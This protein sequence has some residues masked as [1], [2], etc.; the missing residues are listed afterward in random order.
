MTSYPIEA[1]ETVAFTPPS[2]R[3]LPTP[4]TFTLRPGTRRDK[5][6][7]ERLLTEENLRSHDKHA[8]RDEMLKA[9]KELWSEET[10]YAE[11]GRLK[12]YWD[13]SDQF[14]ELGGEGEFNHPDKAHVE[15]LNERIVDA[16]PPLRKMVADIREV[17]SESPRH[18]LRIVLIGWTGI[19]LPFAREGG[20]VPVERID[21]LEAAIGVLEAGH[22]GAVEGVDPGVAFVQLCLEASKML[23][24]SEI[25][26][27]NSVSPSPSTSTPDTL[28]SGPETKD[29]SSS[30]TATTQTPE[31]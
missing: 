29:G 30:A 12:S 20:T 31:S 24:L 2:L 22:K 8:V 13:A 3:N 7:F 23:F 16:W 14:A 4:P 19:D 21:D 15:N 17:R 5:R 6:L 26:R 25:E 27:K 18:L 11:E 28:K 1:A 9:L 10:F